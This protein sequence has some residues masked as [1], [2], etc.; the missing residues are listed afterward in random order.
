[1]QIK[2]SGSRAWALVALASQLI[3]GMPMATHAQDQ[4]NPPSSTAPDNSSQNKNQTKR[5]IA[6][7]RTLQTARLRK[8]FASQSWR[9]SLFPP[10]RTT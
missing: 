10:M 3:I 4:A 9:I 8:R 7:R 2:L 6:R 1:M 5:P